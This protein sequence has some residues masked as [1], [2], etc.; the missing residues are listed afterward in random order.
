M[1]LSVPPQSII[2]IVWCSVLLCPHIM[3]LSMIFSSLLYGLVLEIMY[4]IS[5]GLGE[6]VLIF[7][8]SLP[9]T[10]TPEAPLSPTAL[11]VALLHM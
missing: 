1:K 7:P 2:A 10:S 8:E 6:A 3:T 5:G 9:L 4:G 11:P